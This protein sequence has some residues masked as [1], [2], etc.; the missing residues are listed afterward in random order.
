[1]AGTVRHEKTGSYNQTVGVRLDIDEAIQI[2]TPS[3]VP[4]QQWAATGDPATQVKVEWLEEDL[5]PQH[6]TVVSETATAGVG[7]V[8]VSDASPIRVGD[9]LMERDAAYTKQFLVTAVN[10]TTDTLTVTGFAGNVADP[11]VAA[12]LE[13]IGQYNVEGGDP[14]DP[15]SIEREMPFNYTQIGQEQIAVTRTGRKRGLYGQGDPYDHEVMKKFKELAIRF[16]RSMVNGYRTLSGDAQQRMMGG[17]FFYIATN[18]ESGVKANTAALVNA[19]AK[20]CYE[21][22]GTPAVL[23]VSPSVKVCLSGIDSTLR[24]SER[25]D[26]TAGSVVERILTDFGEFSVVV[27]RHFPKTKGLVLQKEFIKKRPFDSYF[28]ELLAKTGDSEKG[29][30][31]GEYSLEVKNEKAHGVLTI[32]DA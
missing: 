2:L 31:V 3:D 32:T 5:T 8:V 4:L 21:A 24:R 15:R 7:D 26:Q 30:I 29:E 14:K 20:K 1:M 12:T 13:I 18:S 11:T 10:Q 28:H 17:L 27:N 9:V 22:G 19:L 23:M 25:S 16:E 6:V